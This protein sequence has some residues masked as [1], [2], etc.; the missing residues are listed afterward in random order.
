MKQVLLV[1]IGAV[2]GAV[3]T[4]AFMVFLVLHLILPPTEDPGFGERAMDS[5][6][7]SLSWALEGLGYDAVSEYLD[8]FYP[9][10]EDTK[11]LID[12]M[13]KNPPP[14][15]DCPELDAW[16][17]EFNGLMGFD[18]YEFEEPETDRLIE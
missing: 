4:G 11:A 15:C 8:K 10:S 12:F 13:D 9:S 18:E 14:E 16:E 3:L 7:Y 17:K 2:G 1:L 6:I 5:F